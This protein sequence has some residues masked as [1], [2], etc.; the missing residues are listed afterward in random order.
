MKYY[1]DHV[2]EYVKVRQIEE[3]MKGLLRRPD[4]EIDLVEG[5]G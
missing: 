3:S 2:C 1:T 5:E 4:E